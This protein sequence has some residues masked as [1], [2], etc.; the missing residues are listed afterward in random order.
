[1]SAPDEGVKDSFWVGPVR[2]RRTAMLI[3]NW[4]G[5]ILLA[6]G[7]APIAGAARHLDI[8]QD[9]QAL[10]DALGALIVA[11]ILGA[12]GALLLLTRAPFAAITAFVFCALVSALSIALAGAIIIEE[13]L[14]LATALAI[15]P[16]TLML[17]IA[18]LAWRSMAATRA[19]RRLRAE[20]MD[21]KAAA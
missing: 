4:T 5:G 13:P 20:T 1:M 15:A 21:A 6:I 18:A 2:T 7:L 16:L 3:I 14:G 19:L 11:I 9:P 12:P 10:R 17:C 8:P